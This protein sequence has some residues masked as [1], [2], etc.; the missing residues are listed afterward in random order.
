MARLGV[1]IAGVMQSTQIVK[2]LPTP[3]HGF[4]DLPE[5]NAALLGG[6]KTLPVPVLRSL[7]ASHRRN[8]TG[9]SGH[10]GAR[11]NFSE[12]VP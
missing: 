2:R 8:L 12:S 4:L 7:I 1:E 5:A 6:L 9:A 11:G 10:R 3:F